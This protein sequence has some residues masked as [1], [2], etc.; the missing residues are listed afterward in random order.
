MVYA[1]K[2]DLPETMALVLGRRPSRPW[3]CLNHV[4]LREPSYAWRI[5]QDKTAGI[6]KM[7]ASGVIASSIEMALFELLKDASHDKF[8]E[9]Q[10]LIK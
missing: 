6:E 2:H 5:E 9:I 1:T 8:K 10:Q 4:S 7:K 3:L